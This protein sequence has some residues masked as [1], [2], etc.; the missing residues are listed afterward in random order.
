MTEP[1]PDHSKIVA[2]E[3]AYWDAMKAKDGRRTASLSAPRTVVTGSR[4]VTS[5]P[6][7]RM[8]EMTEAGDWTLHD[9]RL[10]DID[11]VHPAPG[12]AVI[13]Y[14]V[15]QDMTMG[16]SRRTMRAADTSTWVRGADGWLCHAHTETPLTE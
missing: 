11:V 8:G 7:D 5:I 12:V 15:E 13:A 6:K 4:G 1:S 16:G 10:D 9:Y 14:V 2:L 3:T